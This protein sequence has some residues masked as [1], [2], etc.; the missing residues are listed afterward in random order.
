MGEGGVLAS[1][2][3]VLLSADTSGPQADLTERFVES[4]PFSRTGAGADDVAVMRAVKRT[5]SPTGLPRIVILGC[6]VD[7]LT[8]DQTLEQIEGFIA[9]RQPVQ[10]CVV[11]ASKAVLSQTD[12]RLRRVVNGCE[13]VNADGQ[14]IVWAARLLGHPVPERVAGIDLFVNLLDLA[15]RRGYGVYFLGATY[16]VAAGVVERA[17][18]EHPRLRICGWH[19][20]YLR[21]GD[22]ETVID[23]VRAGEPDLLFVGM[24][25]PRKEYWLDENLEKL[26]VPFC[27]GVGGSFDVYAGKTARAPLWMQQ[28]GLEWFHRFAKE[29]RRMWRRYLFGNLAFLRLL[30]DEYVPSRGLGRRISDL[31]MV[32]TYGR[33]REDARSVPHAGRR[34]SDR[35]QDAPAGRRVT[36]AWPPDDGPSLS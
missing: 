23:E 8:M 6:P 19:D 22:T 26:G 33:R 1:S 9:A 32:A 4:L 7:M 34:R 36:D 15:E 5:K 21:K 29:P 12:E 10:H 3:D 28:A 14:S 20:G 18:R 24:P 30:H 16:D 31:Y 35:L 27:M 11:N 2:G 13:L 25:S 17:Q